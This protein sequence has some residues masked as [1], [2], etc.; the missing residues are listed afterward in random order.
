MCTH[1]NPV[2]SSEAFVGVAVLSFNGR[3]SVSIM[4]VSFE[5]WIGDR[6][7]LFFK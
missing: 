6:V 3:T 4:S 2:K 1:C 5:A 7:L